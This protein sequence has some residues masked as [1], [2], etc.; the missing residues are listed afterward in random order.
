MNIVMMTNTYLPHVGGVARSVQACTHWLRARG[1]R[2]LVAAPTFEGT[3]RSEFDVTRVPAIQHFNGTDF[4]VPLPL[5]G[6][7]HRE[8]ERFCPDLVHSHHPFLLGDTALRVSA[9][10]D[11]PIVFTHHTQ[12]EKLTQYVPLDSRRMKRFAAELATGYADLCDAVIAPSQSIAELIRARGV[13]TPTSVI[14]TGL[15]V[16][17]FADADGSGMRAHLGIPADATVLG[18]VGRLAP[19]KNLDFLARVLARQAHRDRRTHV[20]VI[21]DGPERSRIRRRFEEAGSANQLHLTGTL[22]GRE[23]IDGYATMN[24]FAFASKVETQGL[25]LSEAMAAGVPVVALAA[26][27]VRDVVRNGDNGRLLDAEDA[28][29]F[30][31]ALDWA[32]AC[33]HRE[34][35]IAGARRT[36]QTYSIESTAGDLLA[37]YQALPVSAERAAGAFESSWNEARRRLR[38]EW[39]IASHRAHTL[40]ESWREP[41]AALD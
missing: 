2:V 16:T 21:G 34:R 17:R 12:Y 30:M 15:D 40:R 25:V 37:L 31:A 13:K 26:P 7:L 28:E 38:E 6:R 23:L 3:S 14:P 1:H 8:L 22:E 35:L 39:V 9:E 19:E 27:G 32:T 10:F 20:V 11:V 24:V 4:S 18:H 5:T 33:E 29:A 36:A 41:R